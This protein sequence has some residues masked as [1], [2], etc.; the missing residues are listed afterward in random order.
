MAQGTQV[1]SIYYDLD[2]DDSKFKEK[3]ADATEQT[4]GFGEQ[5]KA[6]EAGSKAF[7][8]GLAVAVGAL[9]AF[10]IK[11]LQAYS[12]QENAIAGLNQGLKN[13]GYNVDEVSGKLQKQ[14]S[15]L[16]QVSRFADEQIISA[17]AMLTT[18]R[19]QSD[20][21]EKLNPS[22]LDM[23]EGLRDVN[24]QTVGLDEAAKLLGKAMGNAEGGIDGL[25]TALRRNGVI[26]TDAQ[27][28]IFTTGTE[29]ERASTLV[30]ILNFNF[31][32]RAAA[33]AKTF[34][35]QMD[36]MNHNINDFQEVVGKTISDALVPLIKSFNDWFQA[37]GGPQGLMEKFNTVIF[38]Q[39]QA[40][41]PII[42]GFIV[43][44]LVPA[45]YALGVAIWTATLPLLPFIALGVGLG[46]AFVVLRKE[47]EQ[48]PA[49]LEQSRVAWLN[50]W[51]AIVGIFTDAWNGLVAFFTVAIP[52]FVNQ[53]VEFLKVLPGMILAFVW[54]QI[55]LGFFTFIGEI[56]GLAIYGIPLLVQTIM[57]F[58]HEL[59]GKILGVLVEVYNFFV[60][61]WDEISNWLK[62]NIPIM[63]EGMMKF[64]REIPGKVL[65]V[66]VDTK[67]SAVQGITA[68]WD[69]IV[70][71]VK[72]WPGRMYDWGKNLM[73]SFADGIKS[74]IGAIADAFKQGMENA[75]RLVEG[76]SPPVEGPFK[77]IDKWG[78]NIGNAWVQGFYNAF[79][80]LGIPDIGLGGIGGLAFAGAGAGNGGVK[81]DINI[82]VDK[83]G[84]MQDIQAIGRE[85]G[86]R[87]GM[88][89]Q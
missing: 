40:N 22:L 77:D 41:L 79:G 25:S 71:E 31:A 10:G 42:I 61:K 36:I 86:F 32:G 56:V 89:P 73:N 8:A 34:S 84:G 57:N 28:E 80:S 29:A 55:I 20:T 18:F 4:K 19:L 38:P 78:F 70:A 47:I 50:L 88:M 82:Y 53:F 74:A 15:A 49:M 5:L 7:A 65:A 37:Q 3:I 68:T 33:A 16:Q 63:I 44:G 14:A 30:D 46:V 75:K 66:L 23:A 12:E 48:W 59:P 52:A 24:G 17:D 21:I 13:M 81:Q 54:N 51:N 2:L 39:L 85:F 87:A 9:V 6:A 58:M 45:F 83:V 27:K 43:G 26:M 64:I 1:G 72:Q 62:T 67:A 35:G 69:A 60:E 76:H 11:S